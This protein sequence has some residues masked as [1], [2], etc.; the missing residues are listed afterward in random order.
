MFSVTTSDLIASQCFTC[1]SHC[2]LLPFL[3]VVISVAQ[4]VTI[5]SVSHAVFPVIDVFL[6]DGFRNNYFSRST[7]RE[8]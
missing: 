2:Y 8:Q 3:S 7:D 5:F 1:C 4:F 6:D